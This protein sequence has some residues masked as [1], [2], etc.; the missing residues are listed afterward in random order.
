MRTIT[1]YEIEDLRVEISGNSV[2]ISLASESI[3]GY[4][5]ESA[6][7]LNN[8][9]FFPSDDT[10]PRL[11]PLLEEAAMMFSGLSKG[12]ISTSD[13]SHLDVLC[14][15][16][17]ECSNYTQSSSAVVQDIARIRLAKHWD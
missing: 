3:Y 4:F 13:K 7:V 17:L 9:P 1:L 6:I 10:D 14:C 2:K 15:D 5:G 12:L 16:L 8:L 11:S